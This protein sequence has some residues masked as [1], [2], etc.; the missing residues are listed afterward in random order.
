[1]TAPSR[2]VRVLRTTG[3]FAGIG[4]LERGLQRHGHHTV[5][6]S[7]IDPI[8]QAV[9]RARFPEVR[10]T[11][12]VRALKRLPPCD[13]IAAG[14]PCQDLSQC[15]KRDGIDGRHSSLVREVF[16]LIES[17][18]RKPEWLIL[19]NVPFML[20]LDRGQ[21]MTFLT[22]ELIR[23]GYRWAYR[24]V[25]TRSFGLPQRRLRVV[26]VAA[27]S[28]DP[29]RI[30]FAD[31][32]PDR[33]APQGA[34]GYGFYWTEGLT[35]LGWAPDCVPTLKGGSG[36]GIP[37]PPAI[38]IPAERRVVTIDICDA[39][40][41][42]G[43]P[44]NWTKPA[45]L[46]GSRPGVR[47][48]LVGNAVCVRVAA[49]LGRCLAQPR[50]SRC[51]L[52]AILKPGDPWPSSAYGDAERSHS[53]VASAWPVVCKRPPILEFL[54]Y[55]KQPLSA[56]ATAGFLSRARKSR[57]RFTEKFLDDLEHHLDCSKP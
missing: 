13:L 27:R 57:L 52:G 46:E 20:H 35:G 14:F 25:D 3:L 51:A 55:P 29:Q 10:L 15:G 11:G 26:M 24:T 30:L 21:A 7:E 19:E 32:L 36:L 23:L 53:V 9:L 5:L 48:R 56:R 22:A 47:W 45:E 12:D 18:A 49:W 16:R 38:W 41:L 42:Q 54:R 44:A 34:E 43:F 40:R 50:K 31:N 33:A 1:M 2:F 28:E 6:L 39:E 37:S 17:A 8:A 4:G